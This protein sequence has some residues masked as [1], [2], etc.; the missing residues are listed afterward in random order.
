MPE[1]GIS[2][3]R[4]APREI[5]MK[6]VLQKFFDS[7]EEEVRCHNCHAKADHYYHAG[8]DREMC[9]VCGK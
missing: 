5:T 4:L 6:T 3:L 1:S 2:Q 8:C 7:G 9:S